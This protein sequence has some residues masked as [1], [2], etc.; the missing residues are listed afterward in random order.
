[1]HQLGQYVRVGTATLN[2]LLKL[3]FLLTRS[4]TPDL[5][6]DLNLMTHNGV[7]RARDAVANVLLYIDVYI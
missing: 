5:A 3:G 4:N 2:A 7:K 6:C 1:M